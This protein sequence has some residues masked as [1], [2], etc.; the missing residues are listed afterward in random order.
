MLIVGDAGLNGTAAMN[1]TIQKTLAFEK[2][3]AEVKDS[4]I[5]IGFHFLITAL[6]RNPKM[7]WSVLKDCRIASEHTKKGLL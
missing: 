3:M 1:A 6:M 5:I 7:P 2:K 4:F